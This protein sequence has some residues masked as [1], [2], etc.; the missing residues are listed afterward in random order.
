MVAAVTPCTYPI[1][2]LDESMDAV[3]AVGCTI[4]LKP[5]EVTPLWVKAVYECLV[6]AGLP[7]SGM[8]DSGLGREGSGGENQPGEVI[9]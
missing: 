9:A 3:L 4:V 2:M 1:S 8:G 7:V 5:A 6:D